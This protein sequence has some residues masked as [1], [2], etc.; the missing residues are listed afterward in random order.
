MIANGMDKRVCSYHYRSEGLELRKHYA[1][2]TGVEKSHWPLLRQKMA[3]FG[4]HT[5]KRCAVFSAQLTILSQNVRASYL[6]FS[7][8]CCVTSILDTVAYPLAEFATIRPYP[9]MAERDPIEN[10]SQEWPKSSTRHLLR[11]VM[12]EHCFCYTLWTP[13]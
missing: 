4:T 5:A 9:T 8:H 10:G 3:D 11:L 1:G 12:Q 13:M 7:D 2:P 6:I